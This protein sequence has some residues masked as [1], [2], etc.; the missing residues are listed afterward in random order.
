MADNLKQ[1]LHSVG[2]IQKQF[3]DESGKPIRQEGYLVCSCGLMERVR[4]S[5][6]AMAAMMEHFTDIV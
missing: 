1:I 4:D 6:D 2:I 5:T 3:K